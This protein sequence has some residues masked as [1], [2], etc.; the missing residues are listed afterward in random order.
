MNSSVELSNSFRQQHYLAGLVLFE[1]IAIFEVPNPA[2]HVKAVNVIRNLV[3][4]HDS[5]PRYAMKEARQRLAHLYLPLIGV[6]MDALPQLYDFVIADSKQ[7]ISSNFPI[8]QQSVAMAIAG[9]AAA[10]AKRESTEVFEPIHPRKPQLNAE[11][12]RHLLACFMWILKSADE[13]TL[14]GW[15][16]ALP[17]H[18]LAQ[19]LETFQI[20][21]HCFEYTGEE[22]EIRCFRL[23]DQSEGLLIL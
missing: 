22:D 8:I 1:L 23:A 18:R 2:L 11:A 9:T 17:P 16:E 21:V 15:W 20:A 14:K 10:V 4:W 12:T 13:Q 6:I 3:S 7:R 5:D 19:L